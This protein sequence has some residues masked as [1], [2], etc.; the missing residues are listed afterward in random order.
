MT[1]YAW[2]MLPFSILA[3]GMEVQDVG[4]RETV[5]YVVAQQD[6]LAELRP[7][8]RTVC[9]RRPRTQVGERGSP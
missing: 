4:C 1:F 9:E 5:V 3:H 2:L 8:Y 7:R 6:L